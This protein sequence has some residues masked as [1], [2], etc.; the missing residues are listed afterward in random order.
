MKRYRHPASK[1]YREK[2]DSASSGTIKKKTFNQ[3]SSEGNTSHISNK[4]SEPF[5]QVYENSTS[6]DKLGK[7]PNVGPQEEHRKTKASKIGSSH[8][9]IQ[10]KVHKKHIT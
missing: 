3:K 4:I 8:N 2:L 9:K 6:L 5:V 1:K 7:A 10:I